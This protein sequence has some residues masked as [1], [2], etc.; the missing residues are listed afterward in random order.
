MTELKKNAT[1]QIA[2]DVDY[3]Q[4]LNAVHVPEDTG[5]HVEALRGILLRIPDGWGRWISCDRG[6]Y[7][8]LVELDGQLRAL[9]PNY[10][11]H[12]VKEKFGGLRYYWDSGEDVHDPEDPEPPTP[13]R[14]SN[15][16]E[17]D[18]WSQQHDAWSE[19]L[20]AY[21][22]TPEGQARIADL[23]RRIKLGEKLVEA[24]ERRAGVTCE[25]CGATGVLHR[26]PADSHWYKTLCPA[27]AE[28]EKYVPSIGS[29]AR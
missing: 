3:Q 22:Q 19:R 20:D 8:L 13:V 10:V 21:R 28:R 14:D 4:L 26:T 17:R 12:Q 27:C 15:E 1:K 6:W 16:A 25:L 2:L 5:E 7:P 24:A 9:L 23:Q 18:R 11:L 29:D